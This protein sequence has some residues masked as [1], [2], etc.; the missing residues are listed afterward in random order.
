LGRFLKEKSSDNAQLVVW[1]PFMGTGTTGVVCSEFG[2]KFIGS[3]NDQ[4]CF[5]RAWERIT[6]AYY[7]KFPDM[8][9]NN[10]KLKCLSIQN[11]FFK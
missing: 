9:K 11:N 10:S 8:G 3:E 7:T 6:T 1:D 4:Q 2:V 5:E